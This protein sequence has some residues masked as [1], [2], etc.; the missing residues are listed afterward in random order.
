M[1]K[2]FDIHHGRSVCSSAVAVAI[3]S[4]INSGKLRQ[5]ALEEQL[6]QEVNRRQTQTQQPKT[7]EG[8]SNE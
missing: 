5:R 4:Q 2:A 6:E 7:Q 1:K 8:E 3:T